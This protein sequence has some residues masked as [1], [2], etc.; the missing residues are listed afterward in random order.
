MAAAKRQIGARA[1]N[2]AGVKNLGAIRK[3]LAEAFA[4][5]Q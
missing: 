4:L 3:E 2:G 1:A 5:R